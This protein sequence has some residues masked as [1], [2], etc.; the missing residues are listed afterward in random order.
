MQASLEKLSSQSV[1]VDLNNR[2]LEFYRKLSFKKKKQEYTDG[3]ESTTF[4]LKLLD[5]K[6]GNFCY[7]PE[8]F[9]AVSVGRFHTSSSFLESSIRSIHIHLYESLDEYWESSLQVCILF[10]LN[11]KRDFLEK[12]SSALARSAIKKIASC[13]THDEAYQYLMELIESRREFC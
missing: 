13:S 7:C 4:S 2:F 1:K 12:S 11:H 10:N 6:Y 9:I 8:K 3:L 5:G